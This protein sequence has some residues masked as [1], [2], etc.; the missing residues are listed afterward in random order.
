MHKLTNKSHYRKKQAGL[1]GTIILV[2]FALVATKYF[3]DFDIVTYLTSDKVTGVFEY[4]KRFF[5][6]VW[7]KYI[8]GT[9]WYIWN[10]AVI[11]VFWKGIVTMYTILT[12]LVDRY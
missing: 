1:I 2:V 5:E 6:I 12:G 11:D 3:L 4:I 8:A 10:N 9:F 7:T